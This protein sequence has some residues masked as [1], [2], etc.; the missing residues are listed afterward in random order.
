MTAYAPHM[1][2]A[3]PSTTPNPDAIKFTLDVRL[4]GSINFA[5][6]GAAADNPF[7]TEVFALGGVAAV[8][9]VNDFVTI[10]RVAGS[11]WDPIVS[12][13]VAAAATHL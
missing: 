12:G 1:A 3:S 5:N 4:P 11:D 7:A 13:V 6:A 9:G 10:T 8:F 2:V